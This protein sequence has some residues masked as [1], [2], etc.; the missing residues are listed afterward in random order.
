MQRN[1]H[2]E[3]TATT[4]TYGAEQKVRL[5]WFFVLQFG[6]GNNSTHDR[7]TPCGFWS[8][9]KY[10]TSIPADIIFDP[11]PQFEPI[12]MDKSEVPLFTSTQ[13]LGDL[14]SPHAQR[15]QQCRCVDAVYLLGLVLNL[16]LAV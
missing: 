1:Y 2:T 10:P 11:S 4:I 6:G 3:T 12:E 9:E 13:V 15:T 8:S 7:S 5:L 16:H 14:D